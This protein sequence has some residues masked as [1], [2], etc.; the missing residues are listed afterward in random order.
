MLIRFYFDVE[1]E[2]LHKDGISFGYCVAEIDEETRSIV[3][4]LE[5]GNCHSIE[6]VQ[7]ARINGNQYTKENVIPRLLPIQPYLDQSLNNIDPHSLPPNVVKTKREL[8]NRFFQIYQKYA[9]VDL[10]F[11]SSQ[12]K[13]NEI[14]KNDLYLYE[15]NNKIFYST[16]TDNEGIVNAE[17]T[18]S[19]YIHFNHLL[20]RLK[21]QTSNEEIDNIKAELILITSNRGHT[22]Y[23]LVK[24]EFWADVAWPVESNFLREI[25]KDRNGSRDYAMPLPLNDLSTLLHVD[26]SRKQYCGIPTLIG[27]DPEHDAMTVMYCLQRYEQEEKKASI[28]PAILQNL[29]RPKLVIDVCAQGL[30]HDAFGFGYIVTS[31]NG[32]SITVLEKGQCFSIF[33]AKL[34]KEHVKKNL[35]N[36]NILYPWLSVDNESLC[37]ASLPAELVLTTKELGERCYAILNH[38]KELGADIYSADVMYPVETNFFD[39]IVQDNPETTTYKMPYPVYDIVN[40]IKEPVSRAELTQLQHLRHGNP[41]HHV[42]TSACALYMTR[43]ALDDIT[44]SEKEKII[45][46]IRR[47]FQKQIDLPASTKYVSLLNLIGSPILSRQENKNDY[48]DNVNCSTCSLRPLT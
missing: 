27:R 44:H 39:K 21:K 4:I 31:F 43:L 36:L 23:S 30:Q 16:L 12:P 14:I 20:A 7:N 5:R 18:K 40:V 37:K 2:A 25:V 15:E 33:S 11:M 9:G 47:E 8:R 42:I 3:R 10:H 41:L 48:N 34:V 38:W 1:A 17:I 24:A 45:A 13:D 22:A 46:N 6:G 26:V 32:Q 35:P 28:Q 29:S 19:E